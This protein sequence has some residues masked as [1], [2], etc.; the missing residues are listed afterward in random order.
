MP[1]LTL[2][3]KKFC[4]EYLID[5]NATRA[6]LEAYKTTCK[7]EEAAAASASKLLRNP[8]VSKYLHERTEEIATK[9]I[10]KTDITVER[11][12]REYAKLGFFD[13]RKLFNKDGSPV[14]ITEL[15]DDTAAAIVGVDVLEAWEGRG[16]NRTFI[17]Y[18]KKYKVADKKGALDSIAKYLGMFT[19]KIEHSGKIET[20]ITINIGGEDYET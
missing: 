11:V 8:K 9:V 12:L 13:A 1:K 7:K 2:K 10:E 14:D 18:I 6:Y 19:E 3:Q 20:D 15:D 16:K 5:G 17:G 4:E